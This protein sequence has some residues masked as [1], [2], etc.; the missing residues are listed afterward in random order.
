[1]YL[2][3]IFNIGR[4]LI[5]IYIGNL[6]NFITEQDCIQSCVS[7]RTKSFIDNSTVSASPESASSVI[8]LGARGSQKIVRPSSFDIPKIP[9]KCNLGS[10]PRSCQ[11]EIV[12]YYY[13]SLMRKCRPFITCPGSTENFPSKD[14]CMRECEASV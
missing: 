9:E 7:G 11:D 2:I 6:N 13:D 8:S 4:T 5:I 10:S 12:R 14:S 1:M 3:S